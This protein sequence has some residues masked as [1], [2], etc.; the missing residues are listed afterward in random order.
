MK[1]TPIEIKTINNNAPQIIEDFNKIS[2]KITELD[3]LDIIKKKLDEFYIDVE[4]YL[5]EKECQE[6]VESKALI[7]FLYF[8]LI[9]QI[10]L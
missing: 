3:S 6:F 5:T 8:L 7:G 2:L 10:K 1:F 4:S 9:F